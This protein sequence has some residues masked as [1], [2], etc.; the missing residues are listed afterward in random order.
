VLRARNVEDG[1]DETRNAEYLADRGD[2]RVHELP[3]GE[4]V[5]PVGST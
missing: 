2:K 3:A 5:T 4:D 1:E